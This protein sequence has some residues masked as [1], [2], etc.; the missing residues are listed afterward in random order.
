M[1]NQIRIA[2]SMASAPFGNL[3]QTI[4]DLEKAGV[5]YFHFDLEDGNFVPE[6]NLGTRIISEL[7]PFTRLPFDVHLMLTNPEWILPKLK[8]C[9][10]NRISFHLEATQY[11]RRVLGLIH[12]LGMQAGLALNPA[13]PLPDLRYLMPLLSF[14]VILT[15]EPELPAA[16][17]LPHVLVKLEQGKQLAG[18]EGIEWV[19]D[20]GITCENIH[21][22]VAAGATT[23]VAG[24]AIFQDNKIFDNIASLRAAL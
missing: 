1:N 13:T 17:F 4:Q 3:K 12:D 22:V 5:D 24:R 19:A 2:P 23:I 6:M 8:D 15:S 10:V 14:I 18:F 21:N 11:P 16:K 9:D 20:G 7:R